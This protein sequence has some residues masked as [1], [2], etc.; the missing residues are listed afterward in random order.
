MRAQPTLSIRPALLP[1]PN[2]LNES[3]DPAKF[4]PAPLNVVLHQ[5]IL[6]PGWVKEKEFDDLREWMTEQGFVIVRANGPEPSRTYP[7][8]KFRT[9][10]G[11]FNQAFHVTVMERSAGFP[12]CYSVF[13]D[14]VMPSRF[15][16]K[17][18]KFIEGYSLSADGSGVRP[19]CY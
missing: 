18:A 3:A 14:P 1:V 9:N 2:V 7:D 15:A 4:K 5:F 8:I 16:A 11:K 19:S 10:V 17:N 13:T 12:W 6:L